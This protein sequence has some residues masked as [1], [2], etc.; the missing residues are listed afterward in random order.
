MRDKIITI[1]LSEHETWFKNTK[2]KREKF[3]EISR[4]KPLFNHILKIHKLWYESEGR[5][6]ERADFS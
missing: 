6:G 3:E 5:I 4:N 1:D 2:H